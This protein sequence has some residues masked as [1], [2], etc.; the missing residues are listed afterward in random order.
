MKRLLLCLVCALLLTG[1]SDMVKN[2][3]LSVEPHVEQVTEAST[4]PAQEQ[5]VI[6]ANRTELRGAV[7]SFIRNWQEQGEILVLNYDGDVTTDLNDVLYYATQEDP[8]GAYA[9]DYADAEFAGTSERGRITLSIVFRR[10]AAE[11]DAI[12]TV[13]GNNGAYQKIQD[14][15]AGYNASLTLRIRNYQETDFTGYIRSYCLENPS[16][17]VALPEVSA[18]VYPEEGSIRILELHFSYPETRDAMREKLE[19]VQTILDSASA[20]VQSGSRQT[21]QLELLFRFLTT[22]SYVTTQTEPHMPAYSLLCE[23]VAHSL[24]FSSV[25]YAECSAANL[26]CRI[27][28]GTRNG[29]THY[30]NLLYLNGAYYHVDLLRSVET[31][32]A[33]LELLYDE[34]LLA[35]GYAWNAADYPAAPDPNGPIPTEPTETTQGP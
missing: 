2:D 4:L 18:D 27:V 8:I 15:L 10:S 9:V 29:E 11:I 25:F 13:S 23:N 24:G 35:E 26:R 17:V 14:A 12:V 19:S 34:D 21:E 33:K 1:C 30:W 3:Y 7:L 31:G 32:A 5:N 28:S 20:Y 6:V 16:A 22:R